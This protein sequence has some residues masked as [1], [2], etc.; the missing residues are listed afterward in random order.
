MRSGPWWHANGWAAHE[1]QGIDTG[2]RIDGGPKRGELG[3]AGFFGVAGI[4]RHPLFLPTGGHE[5]HP[6]PVVCK[7]V[8]HHGRTD[9]HEGAAAVAVGAGVC[10][11]SFFGYRDA[12][13]NAM[14]GGIENSNQMCFN[15][16]SASPSTAAL[17]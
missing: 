7:G 4:V 17:P 11:P 8:L 5:Y 2:E 10:T 14:I 12:T 9:V 15:V 13:T 6:E 1:R 3:Q 16:P